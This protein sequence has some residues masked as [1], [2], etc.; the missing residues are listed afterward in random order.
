MM[1]S[2]FQ[3][4]SVDIWF[5]Y[6]SFSYG[7]ES[8]IYD[9]QQGSLFLAVQTKTQEE[10]RHV[11]SFLESVIE[12]PKGLIRIELR[13]YGPDVLFRRL[14]IQNPIFLCTDETPYLTPRQEGSLVLRFIEPQGIS[15][16]N[17]KNWAVLVQSLLSQNAPKDPVH[18]GLFY[19]RKNHF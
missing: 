11:E 5:C 6:G 3:D 1:V 15:A 2:S 4:F 18:E 12:K 7:M 17:T 14:R 19:D 9:Y 10:I 8:R 16:A 13:V